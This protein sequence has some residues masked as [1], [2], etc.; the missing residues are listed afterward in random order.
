[1]NTFKLSSA[2]LEILI[3]VIAT[4]IIVLCIPIY[5]MNEPARLN[6][7][8]T[9]QL[10]ADL[11]E[12]MSL[13][14][15]NC[16]VCHGLAG[17]GIGATPPLDNPVLQETDA[18]ALAKIISRGLYGTSMPAWHLDDGGPL[19]DYQISQL[20]SLIRYGDWQ[21]TQNRVVNLGLAPQV[22][23]T[24]QAD[25]AILEM[26]KTL[27]DGEVL[28]AGVTLFAEQCVAC[29]GADGLGTTLA[30]AL[31]DPLVREKTTEEL[32]RTIR[33][34]VPGTLMS[35]WEKS[36]AD[37]QIASA[38]A[39]ITRWEVVPAGA[40]PAPSQP[41]PVTEES[42]VLGAE[43]YTASCSRCHGPVGQGS[44]RA[45]AL[46]VRSFLTDTTDQAMLQIITLGVPGTAMPVWGDRLTDAQIQAIVGFVRTWE[47][48]APEVAEPARIQGPAFL[49]GATAGGSTIQTA[50]SQNAPWAQ[51]TPWY[52]TLDWRSVGMI[53]AVAVVAAIM[54]LAA[55]VRLKRLTK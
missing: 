6:T 2:K 10:A 7:A 36:L 25:P 55:A 40:I 8:Q 11:D 53:T 1:M 3:G 54:V 4:A 52:Q 44:Q 42:L 23:F 38:L 13:Y 31:N 50:G 26:V 39:L 29:H 41:I 30:P 47:P 17:T 45:P 18:E 9:A 37:E 21:A 46:N 15:E 5:A 22:P 27:P 34:G 48:T 49:P 24:T 28:A 12:G 16:S 51:S 14:A 32:E 35:S 20:T 19:S 43:L 33:L